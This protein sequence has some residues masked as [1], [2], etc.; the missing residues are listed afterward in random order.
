MMIYI[1]HPN[2]PSTDPTSGMIRTRA[3]V[4]REARER[5]TVVVV[6]QDLGRPPQLASRLLT[7][8]IT[9]MDDNPPV[10]V[11]LPVGPADSQY[12][13]KMG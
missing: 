7:I 10:F 5:Y 12:C 4:D 11:R 2:S 1:L 13:L 8:N 3:A 6:A 9:D